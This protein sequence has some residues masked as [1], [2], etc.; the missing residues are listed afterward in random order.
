VELVVRDTGSGMDEHTQEHLFEPF[1]T[2]KETGKG[3]G[4][5]LSTVHGIVSQSGGCIGVESEPGKG[6]AFY[7]YLPAAEGAR[8]EAKP[9][10][11]AEPVGGKESVLLVEDN[12]DVRRFTAAVLHSLG[13]KVVE[14]TD[15][16]QALSVCANVRFDLLLTDVVMPGMSGVELAERVRSVQP[17]LKVLLISGYSDDIREHR[18]A[19]S[20]TA[21]LLQ[22]PFTPDALAAKIREVLASVRPAG[23]I[24]VV[25]DEEPIRGLLR[26]ILEP[27]GYAVLEAEDGEQALRRI[28][29]GKVDLILTDLSMPGLSGEA[30]IQMLRARQPGVK[31]VAMSGSLLKTSQ[32][33]VARLDVDAILPKPFHKAGL[34]E[35]VKRVTEP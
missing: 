14:A 17:K 20:E 35:M 26:L 29:A 31:I 30:A 10:P 9:A 25:D 28:E 33:A 1:F 2:T 8:E 6:S 12:A 4:L 27:A 24:L 32:E 22:K 19:G 21:P 5:G 34:L 16:E 3:T 13:Y 18:G 23:T 11:V 7:V 15:A